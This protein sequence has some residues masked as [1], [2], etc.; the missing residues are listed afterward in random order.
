MLK[1]LAV[2]PPAL[3][4][5][6]GEGAGTEPGPYKTLRDTLPNLDF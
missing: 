4:E 3:Q 6:A 2:C 5:P 1:L